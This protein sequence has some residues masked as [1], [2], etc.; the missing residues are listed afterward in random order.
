MILKERGL[1]L[2]ESRYFKKGENWRKACERVVNSIIPED[3]IYKGE[4]LEALYALEIM[5][6][7]P[8]LMNAGDEDKRTTLSACYLL[9]APKDTLE[10]ISELWYNASKV[11]SSGG[12]IGFNISNLRPVNA[13]VK[14]KDN[15][16]GGVHF[17]YAFNEW[18][19]QLKQG[20][21]NGATM[22][23]YNIDAPDIVEFIKMKTENEKA[24]DQANLSVF[25]TKD[26]LYKLKHTPDA[27]VI[28]YFDNGEGL[29]FEKEIEYTYQGLFDLHCESAWKCGCPGILFDDNI[30]DNEPEILLKRFGKINATN[31]CFA[32]D[33]YI[34]TING[35]MTLK[36]LA[37]KDEDIP[38]LT[39]DPVYG[40]LK[41][42]TGIHP[43]KTGVNV[44]VYR[45]TLEN[46]GYQDVTE[47][48]K[49][50]NSYYKEIKT[51]EL[52]ESNEKIICYD[53][54]NILFEKIANDSNKKRICEWC[55]E[56]LVLP[57]EN[58][59]QC[60]CSH[61]CYKAYI[62]NKHK[63]IPFANNNTKNVKSVE[64]LNK[65]DVYNITVEDTH[66]IGT[67]LNKDEKPFDS[68]IFS[69]QCGEQVLYPNQCCCLGHV[70]LLAC[71]DKETKQFNELKFRTLLKYITIL[72]D[73]VVDTFRHP[74]PAQN[75]MHKLTRNI[76]VGLIGLAELFIEMNIKYGSEA[77]YI[78]AEYIAKIWKE[79]TIKVSQE[80]GRKKGLP[81][82]V[83]N[84][85]RNAKLTTIAPTGSVSLI[86][87][88]L[89]GGIE[90]FY[91]VEFDRVDHKG[92]KYIY[93]IMEEFD[94][95]NKDVYVTSMDLT[96]EQ[97]IKMQAI[98]QKYCDS[99]ISKTINMP[100]TATVEDV[101]KAYLLA[102]ELG[103]KG[104]TI[105]RDKSKSN[106]V[107]TVKKSE[108]ITDIQLDSLF[109]KIKNKVILE[110]VVIPKEFFMK[111]FKVEREK[112]KWYIF[113]NFWDRE[114]T[115]PFAIWI[116][117]NSTEPT[118]I[119]DNIINSIYS[120]AKE[121]KISEKFINDCKSES[122]GQSNTT[123]IARALGLCLRH[124]IQLV[125]IISILDKIDNIPI[126]SIVYAIKKILSKFIEDGVE[127]N[128]AKCV[129]CG[130][131][132][133]FKEGCIS[134][135]NCG[136][137]KC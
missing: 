32:G 115:M 121:K 59:E 27:K 24:V 17:I 95:K 31:P 36:E 58:R 93:N 89:A 64:F 25:Y 107:L 100:E 94:N 103:C 101:K 77:S 56:E 55:G 81:E 26:F 8:T 43:R 130:G 133:Q 98:F 3:E 124:N 132:L 129:E 76:G 22:I 69:W 106:Q 12:G 74:L 54:H 105:Y 47:N 70:N 52:I 111:G 63:D 78:F 51:D 19:K 120:L 135:L 134:C 2:L 79:Q 123:K 122:K 92:L 7:T 117:T 80:L 57:F 62:D 11:T 136:W 126:Y 125:D 71:F 15:Q 13:K 60:F 83:V 48:H 68:L 10:S 82:I 86:A 46:G 75:E 66:I 128:E 90:P 30:N 96:T 45:V 99:S 114:L 127:Y 9:P 20:N 104:T 72:M 118:I 23:V 97:H 6:N 14:D 119:S 28:T 137:S 65:Q 88:L 38:V 1:K 40:K 50:L 84:N 113:L 91:A 5:P 112:K 131:K 73:Y 49:F 18:M 67:Y 87:G 41:Y 53:S 21:R 29:K 34:Q 85:Q 102:H 44:K 108:T 37:E 4:I 116:T 35:K 33:T 61:G 16:A 110:N 109:Q 39:L 42:K